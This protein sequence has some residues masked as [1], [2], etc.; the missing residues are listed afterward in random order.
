MNKTNVFVCLEIFKNISI[1]IASNIPITTTKS[2]IEYVKERFFFIAISSTWLCEQVS[3]K[4]RHFMFVSPPQYGLN[5]S[6]C[7]NTI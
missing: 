3:R 1:S 7:M 6:K 4:S 5:F 2:N